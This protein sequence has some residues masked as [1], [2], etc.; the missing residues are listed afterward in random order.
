MKLGLCEKCGMPADA[1]Y[2]IR[3]NNVYLVKFCAD[4]GR[5][6]SIV[7]KDSRKWRWKRQ[8]CDYHEPVSS[9]CSMNCRTCDHK[10]LTEPNTVAIDVTNRCNQRC[11][12]CLVYVDAMGFDY[13]PPIEYFDKI[14]QHFQHQDPRPNICF[15]GGEPTVH[16]NF[17]EIVKTCPILRIPGATLHQRHTSGKQGILPG[18]LLARDSSEFRL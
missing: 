16:K 7:S 2:E 15:F 13:H 14:F 9:G 3:N 4:C 10:A 18:T 8:L 5:T 12:I 11:P 17:L 6:S 1:S